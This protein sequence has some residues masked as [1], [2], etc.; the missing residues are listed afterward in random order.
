MSFLVV[1]CF[2]LCFPF[3]KWCILNVKAEGDVPYCLHADLVTWPSVPLLSLDRCAKKRI[4]AESSVTV[5]S[6]SWTSS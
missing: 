2:D 4:L 5:A 1:H 6:S 3:I